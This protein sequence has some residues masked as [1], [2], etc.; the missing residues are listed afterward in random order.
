MHRVGGLWV[1]SSCQAAVTPAS[2]QQPAKPLFLPRACVPQRIVCS[3]GFLSLHFGGLWCVCP[4]LLLCCTAM[5]WRPFVPITTVS[6]I[7][8]LFLSVLTRLLL[9][10]RAGVTVCELVSSV[11]DNMPCVFC[12]C[13]SSWA[14]QPDTA[15]EWHTAQQGRGG[16]R[17]CSKEWGVARGSACN[18]AGASGCCIVPVRPCLPPAGAHVGSLYL[19]GCFPRDTGECVCDG[20]AAA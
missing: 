17:E 20:H 15:V 14:A 10:C 18:M 19:L 1:A 8:L 2:R 12:V 13:T 5:C 9:P 11:C 7:V 4:M 6:R 3:Q 16:V